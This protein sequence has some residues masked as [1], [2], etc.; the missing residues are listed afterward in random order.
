MRAGR[1]FRV[2]SVPQ[3]QQRA[4]CAKSD[5]EPLRDGARW[6]P[7]AGGD[8]VDVAALDVGRRAELRQGQAPVE[9]S[10][11]DLGGESLSSVHPNS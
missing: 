10:T 11:A 2:A 7:A 8:V 5:V 1:R 9:A 4:I 6:P 3:R